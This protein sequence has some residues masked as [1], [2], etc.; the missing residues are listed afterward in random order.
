MPNFCFSMLVDNVVTRSGR[1]DKR[2]DI[3]AYVNAS[4]RECQKR[5][6]YAQDLIED[7]IV[8]TADSHIWDRPKL[9]RT[10]RAVF[11]PAINAY[12]EFIQ[13]GRRQ[14]EYDY[15]YYGGP[16]YY[17]FVGAGVGNYINLSYYV[18]TR[19]FTYY[20]DNT[21]PAY[22]NADEDQWYYLVGG[23]YLI[24]TGDPVVEETLRD[25]VS[26][27]LITDWNYIIEEGALAKV[28]KS[29]N[30]Q[31]AISSFALYKSYQKDLDAA[32]AFEGVG[33]V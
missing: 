19:A 20:P 8:A 27:W 15:Y 6:L 18:L 26:H 21:T 32:A 23:T 24:T 5:N 17:V 1:P 13:P 4:L 12:P 30:D 16:S 25:L 9:M 2:S 11:Y 7:Q 28:Y 29:M 31:R 33:G 3:I 10:V 14:R 22:Y